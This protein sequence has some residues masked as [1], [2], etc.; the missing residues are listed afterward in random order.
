M[1]LVSPT[2][3]SQLRRYLV[4]ALGYDQHRPIG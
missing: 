2:T 4:D 3:P 1:E